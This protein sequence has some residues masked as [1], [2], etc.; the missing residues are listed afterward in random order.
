M[1]LSEEKFEE[2]AD[3]TGA[4]KCYLFSHTLRTENCC[5]IHSMHSDVDIYTP[6]QLLNG[7][8][9]EFFEV[10]NE[11]IKLFNKLNK[12]KNLYQEA[13]SKSEE[14]MPGDF[15]QYFDE[16]FTDNMAEILYGSEQCN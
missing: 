1:K 4:S 16:D 13:I 11:R 8:K 10:E 12:L 9:C 5:S 3:K 15:K 6:C 14:L 7:D 2:L